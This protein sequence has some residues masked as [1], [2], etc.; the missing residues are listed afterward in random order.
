MCLLK[1]DVFTLFSIVKQPLLGLG[2]ID[3]TIGTASLFFH[4]SI[5]IVIHPFTDKH[6]I[7]NLLFKDTF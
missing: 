7:E 4:S 6:H 1:R 5:L 2:L 3:G